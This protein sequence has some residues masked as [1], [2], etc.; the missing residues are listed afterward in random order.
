[1]T[2][3]A[4]IVPSGKQRDF[5]GEERRRWWDLAVAAYPPYAG[6]QEKTERVIPVLLLEPAPAP[7]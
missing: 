7:H 2:A 4:R 3:R 1:M 5:S 6:Y